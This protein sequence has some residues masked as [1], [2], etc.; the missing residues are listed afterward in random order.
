MTRPLLDPSIPVCIEDCTVYDFDI[1]DKKGRAVGCRVTTSQAGDLFGW[2][3][4]ALRDGRPF[5]PITGGGGWHATR[6]ERD[7]AVARYVSGARRR[8]KSA[9]GFRPMTA[10]EHMAADRPPVIYLD[11]DVD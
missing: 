10:A 7:A 1:V 4:A 2:L 6:E 9:R 3:G 11:C 5:G 8:A